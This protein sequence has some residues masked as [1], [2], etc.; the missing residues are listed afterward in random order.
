MDS[1]SL[2]LKKD[3]V[4]KIFWSFAIPSV[5]AILAQST[6]GFIDSIFIGRY[7]GSDGLS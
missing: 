3:S 4:N 7:I 6:A 2:N 5:L 1:L